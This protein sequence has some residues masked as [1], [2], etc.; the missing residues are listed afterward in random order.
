M[1]DIASKMNEIPGKLNEIKRRL[2][3]IKELVKLEK[4]RNLKLYIPRISYWVIQY[5]MIY[6]S[7][8]SNSSLSVG[9]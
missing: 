3:P 6:L 7:V 1:I 9:F 4:S 5:N 2:H 8:I